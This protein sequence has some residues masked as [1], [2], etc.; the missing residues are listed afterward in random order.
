MCVLLV[1]LVLFFFFK[2]KT[3]YEVRISDWSSDVCSSDLSR[4]TGPASPGPLSV[5]RPV[6]AAWCPARISSAQAER[7]CAPSACP[8]SPAPAPSAWVQRCHGPVELRQA[9]P[10]C[11]EKHRTPPR[12]H[13]PSGLLLRTRQSAR[14]DPEN[15]V[16]P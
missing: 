6:P 5:R 1:C 14:E 13:G 16:C 12:L 11:W 15:R 8:P 4:P 7:R 3:A 2:Q 10:P 9:A